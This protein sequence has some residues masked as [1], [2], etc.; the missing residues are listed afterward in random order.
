MCCLLIPATMS[1]PSDGSPLVTDHATIAASVGPSTRMAAATADPSVPGLKK[2]SVAPN[3]TVQDRTGKPVKLSDYAGKVVVIDF[4]SIACVPCQQMMPELNGLARKFKGKNVVFLTMDFL[5]S[6]GAFKTWLKKH[7][8]YDAIKFLW[9]PA[10]PLN[11]VA[12]SLY[13]VSAFPVQFVVDKTGKIAFA[14]D[15][16]WGSTTALEHAVTAA[17]K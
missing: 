1:T 3:F 15:G 5:D 17:S 9:D 7:N 11:S 14:N 6:Q 8:S 4:W 13:K 10:D 2:G 16:Y 12:I